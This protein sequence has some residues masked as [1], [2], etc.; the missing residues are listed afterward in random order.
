[1]VP[2]CPSERRLPTERSDPSFWSR[3][4]ERR[5]TLLQRVRHGIPNLH[6]FETAGH[7]ASYKTPP[8]SLLSWPLSS[9]EADVVSDAGD[10]PMFNEARNVLGRE[11][12]FDTR[13]A[14]PPDVPVAG[15]RVHVRGGSCETRR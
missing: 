1:M 2:V 12:A 6:V 10:Q 13:Q 4:K 3:K 9:D 8:N 15:R 5:F 7:Y 11:G 14:R